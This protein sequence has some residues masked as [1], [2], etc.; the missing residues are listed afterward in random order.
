MHPHVCARPSSPKSSAHTPSCGCSAAFAPVQRAVTRS[1]ALE[2]VLAS[3]LDVRCTRTSALALPPRKAPLTPPPA[4]APPAT[5]DPG[6]RGIPL[7]YALD[8]A[9]ARCR[10]ARRKQ[11]LAP[12]A[13]S[14][15]PPLRLGSSVAL[16]WS[17]AEPVPGALATR[18]IPGL[19]CL[20][21]GPLP[22]PLRAIAPLLRPADRMPP[23]GPRAADRLHFIGVKPPVHRNL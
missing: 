20:G 14:W 16:P 5:G 17:A 2:G 13:A 23:H 18:L 15:N 10:S 1:A 6:S 7:R 19:R 12:Q 9:P 21:G 11:H 22:R 3:S 8:L 4:A